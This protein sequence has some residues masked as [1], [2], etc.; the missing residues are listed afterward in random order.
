[1]QT[2]KKMLTYAAMLLASE[3][4]VFSSSIN[5]L[6]HGLQRLTHR[7]N[8]TVIATRLYSHNT[9]AKHKSTLLE[10]CILL[11]DQNAE[12]FKELH[13]LMNESHYVS[14]QSNKERCFPDRH[15]YKGVPFIAPQRKQLTPQRKLAVIMPVNVQINLASIVVRDQDPK[16]LS[17]QEYEEEKERLTLNS[18]EEVS[19]PEGD[20]P[21]TVVQ[22]FSI[23]PTQIR[24]A[25]VDKIRQS[26]T[27]HHQLNRADVAA[28]LDVYTTFVRY[29]KDT[30]TKVL[31]GQTDTIK[32]NIYNAIVKH[33]TSKGSTLLAYR[34]SYAR[35]CK[36]FE[37]NP[38]PHIRRISTT[39]MQETCKHLRMGKLTREDYISN[40]VTG[41]NP[42]YPLSPKEVGLILDVYFDLKTWKR[43]GITNVLTGR[44][45]TIKSNIYNA[46]V[47]HALA[48][49]SSLNEYRDIYA[50]LGLSMEGRSLPNLY[51]IVDSIDTQHKQD[52]TETSVNNFIESQLQE[53]PGYIE[54]NDIHLVSEVEDHP[55]NK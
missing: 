52:E 53:K 9:G 5:M 37:N 7:V 4:E 14:D 39:M 21:E 46:I 12:M 47:K 1:M 15:S 45:N 16:Q 17:H 50:R 26:S 43:E 51:R 41:A 22:N 24:Q 6:T 44:T 13:F 42:L 49:R 11:F 2:S 29:N 35:L 20:E 18:P 8:P 10:K 32:S 54:P 23:T 55:K 3:S 31:N 19:Y 38:L 40:I 36:A 25:L 33:A 30:V 34:E 27:N 48:N 28:I